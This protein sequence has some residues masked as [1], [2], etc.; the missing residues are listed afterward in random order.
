EA[1][2]CGTPVVA[3][4]VPGLKDSVVDG[5]TGLLFEYG[6]TTKLSDHLVRIL[7]DAD[8]REKLTKGGISWASKF[9]WDHAADRTLEL[10]EQI[11]ANSKG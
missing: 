1:N 3:S 10:I 11:V 4:N 7:S 2:A 9:S 5:E 6:D 8:H